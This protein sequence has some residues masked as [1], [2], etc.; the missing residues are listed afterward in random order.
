[1]AATEVR[2]LFVEIFTFTS[3]MADLFDAAVTDKGHYLDRLSN[4]KLK[5]KLKFENFSLNEHGYGLRLSHVPFKAMIYS[6]TFGFTH[7][8]TS[9]KKSKEEIE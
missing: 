9:Y 4:S 7:Q 8:D 5:F 1:M 6:R 2:L 3:K